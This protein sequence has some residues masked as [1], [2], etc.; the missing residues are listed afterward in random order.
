MKDKKTG[1]PFVSLIIVNFNGKDI[2]KTA[3]FSMGRLI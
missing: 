3:S 2:L 1:Y